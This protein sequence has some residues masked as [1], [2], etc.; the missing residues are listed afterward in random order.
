MSYTKFGP[1]RFSRFDD[2]NQT[3]K[4]TPRQTNQIYIS[5]YRDVI[6]NTFSTLK[7]RFPLESSIYPIFPH[8]TLNSQFIC[9][10]NE[11]VLYQ[12]YVIIRIRKSKF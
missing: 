4:Q 7:A 10:F 12:Y 6:S 11:I 1:D 8:F 5:I 9:D 2:T 3:N